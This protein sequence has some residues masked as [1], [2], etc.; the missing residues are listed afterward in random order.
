MAKKNDDKEKVQS[1]E[2]V[3]KQPETTD[4]PQTK[5]KDT[6]PPAPTKKEYKVIQPFRDKDTLEVYIVGDV[7]EAESKRIKELQSLGFLGEEV[8]K[9]DSSK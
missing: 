9:N 2:S 1:E 5:E 3:P 6:P 8:K 7:Y 4:N